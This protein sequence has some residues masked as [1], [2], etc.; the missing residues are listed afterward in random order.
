MPQFLKY[1]DLEAIG[2]TYTDAYLQL[3]AK[4]RFPR[5]V[6]GIGTGPTWPEDEI[7]KYLENQIAASRSEVA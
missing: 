3:E 7:R 5:R 1:A 4:G 2:I 6:K